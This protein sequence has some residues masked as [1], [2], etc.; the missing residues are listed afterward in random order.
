[1][2]L[3]SLFMNALVAQLD[4]TEARI[5]AIKRRC[6]NIG[7]VDPDYPGRWLL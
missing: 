7:E 5:V 4:I 3:D 6:P 2:D 1:M